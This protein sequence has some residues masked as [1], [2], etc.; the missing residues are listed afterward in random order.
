MR[1]LA[2]RGMVRWHEFLS[3]GVAPETLARLVRRRRV[4]RV[5]RGLY[6]KAGAKPSAEHCLAEA[7]KMVPRGVVCLV[8]ALQFHRLTHEVPGEIWI[9][10]PN[11]TWPPRIDYPPIHVVNFGPKAYSLCV[12]T[13]RIE[14][15]PVQ[16]YGV[17]K[18]IVDCFRYRNKIGAGI[19]L[20]ALD[21]ALA[22][23]RCST[24]EVLAL[25]GELRVSRAIRPYLD[26]MAR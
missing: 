16:I 12:E 22:E 2:E 14:R 15:V 7:A 21:A 17:A 19:A 8:S 18:T 6:Q 5:A 1:L 10:I 20:N 4:V 23:H 13:R 3:S 9:A 26:A 25:A 24:D 11:S